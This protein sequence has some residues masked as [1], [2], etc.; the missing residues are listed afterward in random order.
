MRPGARGQP[1]PGGGWRRRAAPAPLGSAG[2]GWARLGSGPFR[3]AATFPPGWLQLRVR[4][5]PRRLPEEGAVDRRSPPRGTGTRTGTCRSS[6]A[7]A[8]P[9]APLPCDCVSR[10]PSRAVL[11]QLMAPP[12]LRLGSRLPAERGGRA[13]GQGRSRSRGG[14]RAR[15]RR[16]I[17]EGG[18][19][20]GEAGLGGSSGGG[21]PD[22]AVRVRGRPGRWW[23]CAGSSRQVG[24]E[25][26]RGSGRA[27]AAVWSGARKFTRE[28]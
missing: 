20:G 15:E 12:P 10:L 5:L 7:A 23:W 21:R 22:A 27:A 25:V 17:G 24:E 3:L 8:L 13:R 28:D 14:G 16:R 19:G 2:L 4:A 11:P 1:R 9:A 26:G 18:A 6:A